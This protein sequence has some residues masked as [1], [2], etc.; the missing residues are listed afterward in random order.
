LKTYLFCIDIILSPASSTVTLAAEGDTA[1]FS[2]TIANANV[3]LSIRRKITKFF[4]NS[5]QESSGFV[6][7]PSAGNRPLRLNE[8]QVTRIAS[9]RWLTTYQDGVVHEEHIT[10]VLHGRHMIGVSRLQTE[11]KI[12]DVRGRFLF[13]IVTFNVTFPQMVT[14]TAATA[15]IV[16]SSLKDDVPTSTSTDTSLLTSTPF[17]IHKT[18]Q[19]RSLCGCIITTPCTFSKTY[20]I[21]PKT[22]DS[23][24]LSFSSHLEFSKEASTSSRS[25]L[26]SLSSIIGLLLL[27][28]ALVLVVVTVAIMKSNCSHTHI[29]Q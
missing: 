24:P 6:Y 22:V 28:L 2:F 11:H 21:L 7:Y 1:F 12:E 20:K 25:L 19:T 15:T 26:F 8:T 13:S 14:A 29:N 5:S 10:R 3:Q 17:K 4:F 9:S 18:T 23:I 16:E 27:T